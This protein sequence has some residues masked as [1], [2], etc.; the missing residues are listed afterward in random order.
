[1]KKFIKLSTLFSFPLILMIFFIEISIRQIPTSYLHKHEWMKEHASQTEILILGSSHGYYGINPDYF[2]KEAFNL[3]NVSQSLKYDMVL[4][5]KYINQCSNLRYVILPISYFSFSEEMENSTEWWRIISYRLYMHCNQH[6]YSLKYNFEI[7]CPSI[8][9]SKF[10]D[11]YILRKDLQNCSDKGFGTLYSLKN[12]SENWDNGAARAKGNTYIKQE[13]TQCN[14]EYFN[15]IIKQCIDKNIK[16]ILITTPT[17]PSFYT[18]LESKQLDFM[19]QTI[20][21]ATD[22]HS[23]IIYWDFTGD[24]RFNN[25]DFFDGDHLSDEGAKKLTH[26]LQQQL[27]EL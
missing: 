24:T 2:Q 16:L 8:A 23:N 4:L 19:Y 5:E 6:K 7:S 22:N 10:I 13:Y 1:M 9:K 3:A 18:N 20:N 14:K 25:D 21:E 17:M 15:H 12:K 26:I 27:N 11:Y